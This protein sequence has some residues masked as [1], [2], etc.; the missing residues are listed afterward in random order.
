MTKKIHTNGV[1]P[2]RRHVRSATNLTH[3]EGKLMLVVKPHE[4]VWVFQGLHLAEWFDYQFFFYNS[5]AIQLILP[6]FCPRTIFVGSRYYFTIFS[7]SRRYN[8]YC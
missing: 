4:V 7:S 8:Y 6:D 1:Y 5:I 3:E 2:T